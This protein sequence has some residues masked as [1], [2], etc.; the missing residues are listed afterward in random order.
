MS[1]T[2]SSHRMSIVGCASTGR[3]K[4]VVVCESA[5]RG[6]G[7]GFAVWEGVRGTRMISVG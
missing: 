6:E 1:I 5:T 7:Y 4:M 2:G 3:L